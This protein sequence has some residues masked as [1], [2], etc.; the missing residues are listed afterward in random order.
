MQHVSVFKRITDKY[1]GD[2][3]LAVKDWNENEGMFE[4]LIEQGIITN[5]CVDIVE[6]GFVDIKIYRLTEKG[7]DLFKGI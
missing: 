2:D 4:A 5:E 3:V 7:K 1:N 6:S